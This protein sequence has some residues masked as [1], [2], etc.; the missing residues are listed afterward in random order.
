M[1]EKEAARYCSKRGFERP[2][3]H[4]ENSGEQPFG[5]LKQLEG[6]IDRKD[7]VLEVESSCSHSPIWACFPHLDRDGD[8]AEPPRWRPLTS[9]R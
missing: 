2:K 3:H 5:S 8:T 4:L 6:V 1:D 9:Q 7:D